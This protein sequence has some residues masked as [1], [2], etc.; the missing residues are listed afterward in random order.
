M[1]L[2]S[3]SAQASGW[4][5]RFDIKER[6]TATELINEILL[7]SRDDFSSALNSQLDGIVESASG[8]LALF[9]ERPVKSVFGRVPAFFPKSRHGRAEGPGVAPIVVDP[10]KQEVGSEGILGQLITDY[11]R[12]NIDQCLNHPGPTK[13]RNEKVR[14][15]IILTDFIGS[16]DRVT[17]MLESF[18]H[19]ATLR[20]W[21]SYNLIDF[22]VVA[23]SGL[24]T[25][26]DNVRRHRLHPTVKLVTGCPTIWDAFSGRNLTAVEQLCRTHPRKH[27][28]PL[29]YSYGGALIAFAHGC[30]NNA[31]PILH[32]RSSGW[33]PLFKGRSTS[34]IVTPLLKDKEYSD[35]HQRVTKLLGIRGVRK[36][37]V[38]DDE[39]RWVS[40]MLI[41]AAAENGVREPI[42]VSARTHLP[43]QDVGTVHDLAIRAGWLDMEAGLTELGRRELGRMRRRRRRAPILAS[44]TD[45]HYYPTQ[46]RSLHDR[47]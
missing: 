15:L 41:L 20:S 7:V 29:G 25:G 39:M 33:V 30:P 42:K 4:L 2:L 17:K 36:E 16:G 44:G 47:D 10:R 32:S 24:A 40:T 37:L 46:L 14:K 23:Y 1:T 3:S 26:L 38:S 18:R 8:P 43:L 22:T 19:V 13:M 34:D 12:R 31:P 21:Q 9:A 6:N 28:Q 45:E 5:E 35:V 27:P 11:C